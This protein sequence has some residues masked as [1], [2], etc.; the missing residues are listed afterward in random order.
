[1]EAA[2]VKGCKLQHSS[3]HHKKHKSHKTSCLISSLDDRRVLFCVFVPLVAI[4]G[5]DPSAD[6]YKRFIPNK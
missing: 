1:M 4:P 6:Y 3:I 2:K 5:K